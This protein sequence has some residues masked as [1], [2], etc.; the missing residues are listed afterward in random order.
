MFTEYLE[1]S[2]W[3]SVLPGIYC[4][5]F[6]YGLQCGTYVQK[7]P[8]VLRK[9]LVEV[10]FCIQGSITLF[11]KIEAPIHLGDKT[12]LMLSDSSGLR[13][14]E[15]TGPFRG[16]CLL[17]HTHNARESLNRIS[18]VYGP[19]P[20]TMEQIAELMQEHGGY[21]TIMS[22]PWA[23]GGFR[24]LEDLPADQQGQYCMMKCF[25]LLYLLL[26]RHGNVQMA[27]EGGS[28]EQMDATA[29]G[30]QRY[31]L[32]HIA[33]KVTIEDLSCRFHLSPTACK[34][35]FKNYTGEPI[36]RWLLARRMNLAA[37]L[38]E[39]S[40][41]TVLQ[42]AQAVGYEGTSQFNASFKARYGI[43]PRQY[44]KNVFFR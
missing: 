41:L 22:Q 12:I 5:H 38:L 15:I 35:C 19:M 26:S 17:I 29:A 1:N 16:I 36:H 43:S 25:E 20:F 33:E 32:E 18:Q 34:R 13:S 7:L 28:A 31:L 37:K 11:P 9:S 40:E 39:N 30:I 23:Y 3:Q 21:C 42:I 2:T 6:E 8:A 4:C 14:A 27:Q 44:R 24:A 10:L